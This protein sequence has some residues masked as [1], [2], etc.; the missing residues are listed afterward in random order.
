[1]PSLTERQLHGSA[2][3][4]VFLCSKAC[5]LLEAGRPG[6]LS[7]S[8]AGICCPAFSL[9]AYAGEVPTPGVRAVGLGGGGVGRAVS[10]NAW[11]Q[12]LSTSLSRFLGDAF[13]GPVAFPSCSLLAG[14]Q[15]SCE[16]WEWTLCHHRTNISSDPSHRAYGRV[17]CLWFSVLFW[18]STST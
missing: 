18:N 3:A 9:A 15:R 5:H 10:S 1:M 14:L 17:L 7:P 16:C 4:R 2:C 11:L 8:C 13:S 12:A 6:A